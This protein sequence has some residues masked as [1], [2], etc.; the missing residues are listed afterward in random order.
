MRREEHGEGKEGK[1][2]GRITRSGGKKG[3]RK[4]ENKGGGKAEIGGN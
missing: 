1:R 2:D 4:K 3:R